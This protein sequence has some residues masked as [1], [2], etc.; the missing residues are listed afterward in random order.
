MG[1]RLLYGTL[2]VDNS[3][4]VLKRRF[5][6]GPGLDEPNFVCGPL[7]IRAGCKRFLERFDKNGRLEFYIPWVRE[8]DFT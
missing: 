2:V 1:G 8:M 5:V 3:L 6:C 7:G 4:E